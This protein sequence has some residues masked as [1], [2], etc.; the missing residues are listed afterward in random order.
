M[1]LIGEINYFFVNRDYQE[2]ANLTQTMM[3]KKNDSDKFSLLEC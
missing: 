3:V 1:K 2:L